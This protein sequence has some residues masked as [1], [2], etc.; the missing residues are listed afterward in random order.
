VKKDVKVYRDFEREH[1]NSLWQT[2]FMDAIVVEGVG[3]AHLILY[4]DD[5]SR[6]IIGGQF[7]KD[8]TVYRALS[9]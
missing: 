6:Y 1:P 2:D 7:E 9:L 3:L 5:H 4:L 8:R